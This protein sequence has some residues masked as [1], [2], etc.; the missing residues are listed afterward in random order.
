MAVKRK[1]PV[2]YTGLPRN[3]IPFPQIKTDPDPFFHRAVA[4]E[5][6]ESLDAIF[7]KSLH[8]R[9]AGAKTK[10][11]LGERGAAKDVDALA[12]QIEMRVRHRERIRSSVVSR[13]MRW[14]RAEMGLNFGIAGL[15]GESAAS[16]CQT[17][18]TTKKKSKRKI[19]EAQRFKT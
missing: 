7:M 19:D 13:M 4:E 5:L 12:L 17:E 11:G 16:R 10:A 3:V 18:Q 8:R 2:A 1:L 14:K 15:F 9:L 6:F